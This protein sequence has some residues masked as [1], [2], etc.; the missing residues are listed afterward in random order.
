MTQAPSPTNASTLIRN[1]RGEHLLHLRDQRPDI[2]EP[3]AWSLLGGG[4]EPGDRD[5]EDTAHRELPEFTVREVWTA[6]GAHHLRRGTPVKDVDRLRWGYGEADP[7][8]EVLGG[9]SGPRVLDLGFGTGRHTARLARLGARGDTVETSPTQHERAAARYAS[10]PGLRLIHADAVTHLSREVEPYDLVYAVHALAYID[11]YRLLPALA[12]ALRPGSGSGR[13]VFS[14]LHPNSAGNP[15]PD[16]V[17]AWPQ[18]LPLAGGGEFTVPMWALTP[19]RWQALL[20]EHGLVTDAADLLAAPDGDDPLSSPLGSPTGSYTSTCAAW[21]RTRPA[22]RR[23]GPAAARSR[24][25]Q[26]RPTP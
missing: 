20:A 18:T 12:T 17:R 9:V 3:G 7:G 11:P 19:A 21:T 8:S 22:G 10:V 5:L 16:E 26:P 25:G 14:A 4:R 15:P 13:L 24:R 2:W 1:N 6:Y 23:P